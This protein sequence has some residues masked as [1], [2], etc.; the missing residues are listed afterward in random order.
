MRG[1][2]LTLSH[3]RERYKIPLKARS[4]SYTN[5]EMLKSLLPVKGVVTCFGKKYYEWRC[6]SNN[7]LI[8]WLGGECPAIDRKKDP[9]KLSTLAGVAAAVTV[10][11]GRV[12]PVRCSNGIK[13]K[14]FFTCIS[15]LWRI[16][17]IDMVLHH[18]NPVCDQS[19]RQTFACFL[20]PGHK[21]VVHLSK[22]KPSMNELFFF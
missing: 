3:A 7:K 9:N 18:C 21:V 15:S 20:S 5:D 11:V 2:S 10:V 4:V 14:I 17:L 16:Y 12:P 6:K 13:K 8:T 19:N 22:R 1:V